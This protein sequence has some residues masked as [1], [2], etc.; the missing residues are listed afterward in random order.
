VPKIVEILNKPYCK[1]QD[2]ASPFVYYPDEPLPEHQNIKDKQPENSFNRR[3]VS[4]RARQEAS[5]K[6]PPP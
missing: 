3:D 1:S 2:M 4:N 6:K 5:L